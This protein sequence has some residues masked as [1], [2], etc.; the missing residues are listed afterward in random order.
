MVLFF[1]NL[2]EKLCKYFSVAKLK[3]LTVWSYIPKEVQHYIL[4]KIVDVV[5]ELAT[6]DIDFPFSYFNKTRIV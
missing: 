1:K 6:K 5:G 4:K 2:S 3:F